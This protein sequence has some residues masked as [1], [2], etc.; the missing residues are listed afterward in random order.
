MYSECHGSSVASVK[1]PASLRGYAAAVT[2][3]GQARECEVVL[4]P[5]VALGVPP[6]ENFLRPLPRLMRAENVVILA[7]DVLSSRLRAL[8]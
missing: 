1:Q 3:L 4:S 6:V 7:I 8:H 2:A 5:A